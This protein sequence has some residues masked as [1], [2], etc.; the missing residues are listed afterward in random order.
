M[1]RIQDRYC[2]LSEEAGV[3]LFQDF[4]CGSPT[5][6]QPYYV[7]SWGG[8]PRRYILAINRQALLLVLPVQA[9]AIVLTERGAAPHRFA[10]G[11]RGAHEDHPQHAFEMR[12]R[13]LP[14]AFVKPQYFVCA[15]SSPL[16]APGL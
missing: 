1:W 14:F 16:L 15:P 11:V 12:I 4:L 7:G 8:S 3:S 6:I 13:F 10:G 2:H 5:Y 9:G